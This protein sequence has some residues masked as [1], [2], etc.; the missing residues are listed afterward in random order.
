MSTAIGPHIIGKGAPLALIAGPCVLEE[1]DRTL[2]IA[3]RLARLCQAHSVPLIFKA[4]FDKANRTSIHSYRGPGLY[5][6]L[7]ILGQV[8]ERIG[9]PITTD[10]HHP[11]QA[12]PVAEV[13]DLIQ[14][15][16]FLCRQTDLLVAAGRTKLP[17]NIKKGQFIAP[18]VM[19]HA[20][21]KVQGQ[22][23]K[24]M[25]TERGTFFGYDD[26]VVDMRSM[27]ELQQLDID[28]CF[29][30]THSAQAPSSLGNCSGGNRDYVFPLA[31]AAL[32][33]GAQAIF[34]EVHDNPTKAR[35]DAATQLTIDA[36]AEM[37]PVLLEIH[38]AVAS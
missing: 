3:E 34:V 1:P 24:A 28:V 8:K 38:R 29:D 6:G 7:R 31:K 27:V 23:G 2:R 25:V 14:I 22:G 17:V 35:C 37:L 26:L 5:E 32:A 30:A 11:E 4:S 10:I 12:T 19:K 33:V 15:P 20:V 18:K 13:A 9:L 16:A 36:L 21:D